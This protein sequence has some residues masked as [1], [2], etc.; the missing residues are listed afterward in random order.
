MSVL[1]D[2][3]TGDPKDA[4]KQFQTA[5]YMLAYLAGQGGLVDFEPA[6]HI[7]RLRENGE[8]LPSVTKI[9]RETGISKDFDD[10]S[11]MGSKLRQDISTKRDIGTAVHAASHYYDDDDLAWETLDEQVKPYVEAWATFRQNYPHLKPAVRER[12][13]YHS[14]YRFVGTLD[15]VFMLPGESVIE[16]TERWSV[17]LT[18]GRKVPYRTTPYLDHHGDMEAFKSFAV[19]WHNQCARRAA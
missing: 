5:G 19:T 11:S 14:G 7:Y 15:G 6:G 18:P 13:V 3:A 4:A 8:I 17:Q 12:L 1:L 2:I 16:I 9:L 10:L